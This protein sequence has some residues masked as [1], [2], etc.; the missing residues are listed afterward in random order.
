MVNSIHAM[1]GG[2]QVATVIGK[3]MPLAVAAASYVVFTAVGDVLVEECEFFSDQAAVGLTSL[4]VS[5]D[6]TTSDALLGTTTAATMSGGK[7]LTPHTTPFILTNGKHINM[8]TIGTGTG[9]DL[10]VFARWIAASAGA[11]LS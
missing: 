3:A 11:M 8:V 7:N 9:G 6:N 2:N 1:F 10:K 4:T 5:T